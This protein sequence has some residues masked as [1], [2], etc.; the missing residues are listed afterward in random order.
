M[1]RLAL[2]LP[3]LIAG[4]AERVTLT[5]ARELVALGDEVDVVVM[6]DEGPLREAVPAG[7]RLVVLGATRLRNAL[8]PLVRY[9]RERR[10][11]A[12]LAQMWPLSSIGVV[13][14]RRTATRVVVVEHITLSSS[15]RTW[16][17]LARA[18]LRPIMRWSHPRA[19]ARVAVSH[20][21]ARDLAQLLALPESAVEAIHNPIRAAPPVASDEPDWGQKAA[22]GRRVLG[23][24]SLKPQKNFGLLIQAFAQIAGPDDR[25][26]I[27]GEGDERSR[28][29]G[30]VDT[31]GLGEHV[32]LPGFTQDPGPW[33]ASADIFVLSSDFEGFANVVVEALSHGRTVVSTDCPDGPAEILTTVGRL[34]P[35]GDAEAL[36]QAMGAAL[37]RPDDPAACV[38]RAA[39]FAPA[40]IAQR[41]R[42]LLLG[43]LT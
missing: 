7:V 34:V 24:G 35:V 2:L 6:R 3:S 21:S 23:V 26:A 14:A 32:L 10:P 4:G 11:D 19:A 36:A 9:L 28:L 1:A 29:Q 42:S 40:P 39:D 41:Y 16:P 38:A 5:L 31:L 8:R 30:I 12:L 13:A 15:A 43:A 27:V 37:D 22:R 18:A 25:L 17:R 20:G 33:Y